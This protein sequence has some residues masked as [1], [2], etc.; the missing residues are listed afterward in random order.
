LLEHI[1]NFTMNIALKNKSVVITDGL[2]GHRQT[3]PEGAGDK[4]DIGYWSEPGEFA[5]WPIQLA[6]AGEYEIA[7]ELSGLAA[8]KFTV[9][10][11]GWK[12]AASF[13]GTGSFHD[14]A[15]KTLGTLKLSQGSHIL[16]VK[17]SPGK[18]QPMNLR[19]VRLSP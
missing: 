15:S 11:D 12:L 18:W 4:A 19:C 14:F 5:Q 1:P 13:A 8:N 3:C 2:E 6:R 7:A 16:T 17:P 9:E 10:V